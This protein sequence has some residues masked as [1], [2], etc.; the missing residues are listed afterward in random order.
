MKLLLPQNKP[1]RHLNISHY[2]GEGVLPCHSFPPDGL[3]FHS[4]C[5]REVIKLALGIMC[6]GDYYQS[7]YSCQKEQKLPRQW[8][9][10]TMV[11]RV[12]TRWGLES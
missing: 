5:L 4:P 10:E 6:E 3:S 2:G 11:T 1:R 7:F 12:M 8:S 9:H